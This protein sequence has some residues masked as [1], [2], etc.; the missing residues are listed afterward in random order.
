MNRGARVSDQWYYA[1]RGE[2][3]GPYSGQQL[4]DLAQAGK[5][6]PTDT[7]WQEGTTPG[8][9]ATRV[10][11]LFA[12]ETADEASQRSAI[13]AAQTLSAR[14]RAPAILS[15]D[16]PSPVIPARTPAIAP[17]L[18]PAEAEKNAELVATPPVTPPD[19][20]PKFKR[21]Q[22]SAIRGAIVVSQDGTSV[23]YRKK[24]TKCG[25]EDASKNRMPIRN[26]ITRVT[27]F[28]PK[29]RKMMPV[30]IQGTGK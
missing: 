11:N 6:Q 13:A 26:G 28:C 27:F 1:W 2:K 23:Q 29:C 17:E 9:L 10:R 3:L 22:A 15:P 18:A 19:A 8:V 24:C 5:I 4:Q 25:H 20:Q 21:G 16:L 12:A 30:E 7:I 14:A